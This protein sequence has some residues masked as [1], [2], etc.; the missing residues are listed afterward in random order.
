MFFGRRPVIRIKIYRARNLVPKDRDGLANPF[1]IVTAG[2]NRESTGSKRDTL[3]PRWDHSMELKIDPE[4]PPS[5]I[6]L[7]V[8]HQEMLI[9]REE[10]GMARIPMSMLFTGINQPKMYASGEMYSAWFPLFPIDNNAT[11][12][13]SAGPNEGDILVNFGWYFGAYDFQDPEF[14]E[15]W[16]MMIRNLGDM[17]QPGYGMEECF[18]VKG[19]GGGGGHFRREQSVPYA[20]ASQYTHHQ[21]QPSYHHRQQSQYNQYQQS[22]YPENRP[23]TAGPGLAG[24]AD[25]MGPAGASTYPDDS[26]RYQ[27]HSY[28]RQSPPPYGSSGNP[29]SQYFGGPAD[30]MYG[31]GPGMSGGIRPSPPPPHARMGPQ[32]ASQHPAYGY[33]GYGGMGMG[34][35]MG[36]GGGG[37]DMGDMGMGP[38]P[39]YGGGHPSMGPGFPPTPTSPYGMGMM[40]PH[41]GNPMGPFSDPLGRPYPP[42]HQPFGPVPP[43]TPNDTS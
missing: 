10:M 1:V 13:N 11:S 4:H 34:M 23:G 25:D 26:R 37:M 29:S 14:V 15:S 24:A 27:H 7:R 2:N 40:P 18:G 17:S 3:N 33:G 30:S 42:A 38:H 12:H 21:P 20:S 41:G 19:Y 28:A 9:A 31:G 16:Q 5:H 6:V 43:Y 35:G 39:L 22:A 32:M 8:Y 36:M